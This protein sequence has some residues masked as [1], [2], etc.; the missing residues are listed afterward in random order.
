[1]GVLNSNRR[2][3]GGFSRRKLDCSAFYIFCA[4]HVLSSKRSHAGVLSSSSVD[5]F[6][7]RR[8]VRRPDARSICPRRNSRELIHRFVG[9]SISTAKGGRQVLVRWPR[10]VL[11]PRCDLWSISA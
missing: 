8:P 7:M 2:R 9:L 10:E 11:G 6:L 5:T 4:G 3:V 1:M